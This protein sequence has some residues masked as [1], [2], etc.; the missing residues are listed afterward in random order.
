[1]WKPLED[2]GNRTSAPPRHKLN[3]YR[4]QRK[5][6]ITLREHARKGGLF[7]R[8][9]KKARLACDVLLRD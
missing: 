1:L 9:L 6:I 4:I 5:A 3:R 7:Q 2:A 8:A